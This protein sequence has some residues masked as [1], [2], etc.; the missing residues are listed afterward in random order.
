MPSDPRKRERSARAQIAALTRW[1]QEEGVAGTAA[2]RSAG[3]GQISY[4]EKRVDPGRELPPNERRRRAEAAKRAHF[5]G[6]ALKSAKARRKRKA[7]RRGGGEH[8]RAT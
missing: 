3:P 8:D 1:S 7:S 4:W 6:L 2:A 5:L